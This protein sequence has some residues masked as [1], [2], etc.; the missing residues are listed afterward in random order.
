MAIITDESTMVAYDVNTIMSENRSICCSV[1]PAAA[2]M[3][4][5]PA[6]YMPMV[7]K[8][9]M[10]DAIGCI[11]DIIRTALTALSQRS[12]EDLSNLSRVLLSAL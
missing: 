10:D 1:F 4:P 11:A 12:S 9:I 3:M 5:A 6:Q 7:R 2:L 8:L